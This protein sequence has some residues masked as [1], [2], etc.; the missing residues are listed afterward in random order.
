M[1]DYQKTVTTIN[2][3]TFL[4]LLQELQFLHDSIVG[5]AG[6][7]PDRE[8]PDIE[9]YLFLDFINGDAKWELRPGSQSE[10]TLRGRIFTA[11]LIEVSTDVEQ[12]LKDLIEGCLHSL[13]E[14]GDESK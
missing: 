2:R 7:F 6:V 13:K 9:V 11:A 10:E 12:T 5:S 3:I 4:K 1:T 8:P 14:R